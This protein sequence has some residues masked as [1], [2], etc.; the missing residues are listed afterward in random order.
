MDK[1]L[2]YEMYETDLYRKK[3]PDKI[4]IMRIIIIIDFNL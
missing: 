1:Q 4:D 2:K 3:Y